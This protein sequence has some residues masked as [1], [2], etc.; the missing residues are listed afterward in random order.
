[1]VDDGNTSIVV[2]DV[3]GVFHFN[4]NFKNNNDLKAALSQLE[5]SGYDGLAK[6]D[7]AYVQKVFEE[8]FNHKAFTGRFWHLLRLRR[9]GGPSIGTWYL[10]YCSQ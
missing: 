8:V 2:K 5:S 1:M 6:A 9:V 7:G 3:N 4:G 10:S